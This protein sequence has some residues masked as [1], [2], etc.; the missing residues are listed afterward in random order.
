MAYSLKTNKAPANT[1]GRFDITKPFAGPFGH[2]KHRP[3]LFIMRTGLRDKIRDFLRSVDWAVAEN[4][5]NYIYGYN[6]PVIKNDIESELFEMTK[7]KNKEK[8]IK[9]L[10]NERY[11]V[12]AY[13]RS[14]KKKKG[15]QNIEH[16]IKLRNCLGVYFKKRDIEIL[17][18]DNRKRADA[19]ADGIFF[20]FDNGHMTADQLEEKIKTHYLE[21]GAYQVIFWM[22]TAEHTENIKNLEQNRLNMLF[23]IIKKVLRDKPN[24]ILGAC[25]HSY[26]EDGKLYNLKGELK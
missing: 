8:H 18:M 5:C 21:R 7:V 20:E 3:E 1:F 6:H 25:Y 15:L 4:L 16:D 19:Y 23:D 26:L 9:Y 24:R 2:G 13:G 22:A 10:P 12:F 11:H 14:D 17:T